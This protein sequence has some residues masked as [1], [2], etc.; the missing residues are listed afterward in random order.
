MWAAV[1]GKRP[2]HGGFGRSGVGRARGAR[3][4][5]GPA[6]REARPPH[7]PHRRAR[8]LTRLAAGSGKTLS[9][10]CS[11]MAWQQREKQ[12]IENGTPGPATLVAP[13]PAPT[14]SQVQGEVRPRDPGASVDPTVPGRS[15][16]VRAHRR[17]ACLGS[18]RPGLPPDDTSPLSSPPPLPGRVLHQRPIERRA[19][20]THCSQG[21][22]LHQD[23]LPDRPSRVGAA[24]KPVPPQD[25]HPGARALFPEPAWAG[26][27]SQ[28]W[29]VGVGAP[30]RRVPRESTP[31][32]CSRWCRVS[33]PP[34][35]PPTHPRT[36]SSAGVE[37]ALLREQARVGAGIGG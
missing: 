4:R 14:P 12:R 30:A 22:L 19:T 27:G 3:G 25:G 20:P 21:F 36:P 5:A 23:P 2:A 35:Q 34:T 7:S 11:S 24:A 6:C 28:A 29:D 1:L 13:P 10:L 16:R 31:R 15:A 37:K 33:P 9:L 8:A 18:D 17:T 32:R 26:P